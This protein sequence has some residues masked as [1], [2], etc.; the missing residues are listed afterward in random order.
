MI[1]HMTNLM[2]NHMTNHMINNMTNHM[3]NHMINHMINYMINN[4]VNHM[5][6]FSRVNYSEFNLENSDMLYF[7]AYNI[8]IPN[9]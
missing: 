6:F 9:K 2:I 4:V 5:I 7:G 3:T 8:Y 1:N